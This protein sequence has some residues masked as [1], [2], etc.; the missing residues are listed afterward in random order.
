RI[1]FRLGVCTERSVLCIVRRRVTILRLCSDRFT[2][3]R[4]RLAADFV[5]AIVIKKVAGLHARERVA[6]VNP[7]GFRDR[8]HASTRKIEDPP[9]GGALQPL[10]RL[11]ELRFFSPRR[12]CPTHAH[13]FYRERAVGRRSR[14]CAALVLRRYARG[15]EGINWL[16][17]RCL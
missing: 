2:V 11:D 15:Y 17:S 1:C 13:L 7:E 3:W 12:H 5:F 4:A 14:N 10:V 6:I 16:R 8:T 9:N